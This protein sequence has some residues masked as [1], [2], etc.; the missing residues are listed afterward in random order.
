MRSLIAGIV[1]LGLAGAVSAED[2]K[3]VSKEGKYTVTFPGKPTTRTEKA[4]N[5]NLTIVVLEKG[6]NDLLVVHSDLVTDKDAKPKDI[7]DTAE[8]RLTES[9][10]TNISK[11]K[12]IE[13]GTQ[14][15]SAREIYGEKDSQHLRITIILADKRLYQVIASG[16]QDFVEGKETE[17]FFKSFEITK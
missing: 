12:D 10:K 6:D 4:D 16:S 15:F 5:V 9:F 3:F 2:G 8:K 17:E 13:F 14:K 11:S 7:L 1:F